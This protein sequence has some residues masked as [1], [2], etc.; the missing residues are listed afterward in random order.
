MNKTLLLLLL[1]FPLL[2]CTEKP[3]FKELKHSKI[4]RPP[5]LSRTEELHKAIVENQDENKIK[6]LLNPRIGKRAQPNKSDE[7]GLTAIHLIV[8][9]NRH[10]LFDI[11]IRDRRVDYSIQDK[12]GNT[13]LHLAASFG[14]EE[15]VEKLLR[16]KQNVTILNN[17]GQTPL[18]I[19]QL[20]GQIDCA[21]IIQ[22]YAATQ[23][24]S[25]DEIRKKQLAR[26]LEERDR[27]LQEAIK[28]TQAPEE[29]FICYEELK[30]GISQRFNCDHK[31]HAV[32]IIEAESHGFLTCPLCSASLKK[33]LSEQEKIEQELLKRQREKE[34][35]EAASQAAILALIAEEFI[36]DY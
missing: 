33:E 23:H 8:L 30:D 15:C 35:E 21:K 11:F 3:S 36:D 10:S 2:Q 18:E 26:D 9:T 29:C 31:L 25:R 12:Q 28:D 17:I 20:S 16:C 4:P 13:P 32:C 22:D 27:S 19:A 5:K 1:S 14:Y 7:K 6:K 34:Q 24:T